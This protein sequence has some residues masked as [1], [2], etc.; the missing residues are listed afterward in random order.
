MLHVRRMG[1][2]PSVSRRAHSTHK[3]SPVQHQDAMIQCMKVC[4]AERQQKNDLVELASS[5]EAAVHEKHLRWCHT[6]A[7]D[8]RT[9]GGRVQDTGGRADTARAECGKHTFLARKLWATAWYA[10]SSPSYSH[11]FLC[12]CW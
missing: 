1:A 5:Q 11:P 2:A 6:R 10:A 12:T 9:P 8:R 3:R 4:V 7:S